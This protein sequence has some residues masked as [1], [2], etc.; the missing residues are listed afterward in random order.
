MKTQRIFSLV[1]TTLML[2]SCN[3]NHPSLSVAVSSSPEGPNIIVDPGTDTVYSLFADGKSDYSIVVPALSSDTERSAATELAGYF[4]S[5]GSV[6]VPVITDDQAIW[7]ANSA[8]ISLGDVS[9]AREAGVV[10]DKTILN[11]DGFVFQSKGRSLF[12]LANNDNGILYGS[13]QFAE[14]VLGV[15]FLTYDTTYLPRLNEVKFKSYDRTFIPVFTHRN[16]LTT[17][18]YGS[19][20]SN[21]A[22]TAH[23][24]YTSQYCKMPANKGTDLGWCQDYVAADHNS[25]D[26]VDPKAKDEQGNYLY[27]QSDGRIKPEYRHIW[28]HSDNAETTA[29]YRDN[30]IVYDDPTNATVYDICWT[31]GIQE[32]G[33]IDDTIEISAIKIAVQ[34]MKYV[35]SHTTS[36]YYMFGQ[37]DRANAEPSPET[38]AAALKYTMTG[39][40]IR[41]INALD[42]AIQSWAKEIKLGR[43]VHIV[44]FAYLYSLNPP[45]TQQSDGTYLPIDSTVKP[46]DDLYLQV[47]PI[48]AVANYA[49]DDPNQD[50]S[51]K[52]LFEKWG[53]LSRHIFTWT[54]PAMFRQYF[55]YFNTVSTTA[56]DLRYLKEHGVI[57]PMLQDHYTEQV[58]L[59]QYIHSYVTSHL[60]WN[61]SL[62]VDSLVTEFCQLY[63]GS[64]AGAMVKDIIDA[65]DNHVATLLSQYGKSAIGDGHYQAASYWP[66][67]FLN[68]QVDRFEKA[69]NAVANLALSDD[70]KQIYRDRLIKFELIPQWMILVN[71]DSYFTDADFERA[72][73]GEEWVK[74]FTSYGGRYYGEG[75]SISTFVANGYRLGN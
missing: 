50:D 51:V 52:Q 44:M 34:R 30:A 67:A 36:T 73:Y 57:Y 66:I 56:R 22:Y 70:E 53:S 58:D 54:Y 10:Y 12:I 21:V 74:I 24:R 4:S 2:F 71:Y 61:L 46:N 45:V 15:R 60:Y 47:C 20:S 29:Y 18:S 63:F 26:Y 38:Q 49:L 40:M 39:V 7:N 19:T 9:F 48:R 72:V 16:H 32:D 25:L 42:N 27:L 5:V 23:M 64:V 55:F 3:P 69:K 14:D 6:S 11:G 43:D 37:Q 65:F 28:A 13:Y 17:S 62:N 31:D 41:F 75:K 59:Q 33:T 8:Y 68:Q 35:I 1:C